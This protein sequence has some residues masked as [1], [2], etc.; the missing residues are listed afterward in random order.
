MKKLIALGLTLGILGA[1]SIKASEYNFQ[2]RPVIEDKADNIE[3]KKETITKLMSNTISNFSGKTDHLSTAV[4]PEHINTYLRQL[5]YLPRDTK[6]EI[7]PYYK[8]SLKRTAQRAGGQLLTDMLAETLIYD[9]Y[10]KFD[11]KKRTIEDEL[12]VTADKG[13]FKAGPFLTLDSNLVGIGIEYKNPILT[14]RLEIYKDSLSFNLSKKIYGK[15]KKRRA[16]F[17]GNFYYEKS[18]GYSFSFVLKYQGK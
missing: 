9:L 16:S 17:G 14:P 15:E 5:S 18:R 4:S 12:S 6:L 2:E 13:K 8:D 1:Y 3:T 10:K 11:E 7:P